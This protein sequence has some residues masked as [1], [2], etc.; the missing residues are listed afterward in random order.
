[1]P[2]SSL[3]PARVELEG[4]EH[5]HLSRVARVQAG[6]RIWLVDEEGGGYYAEVEG[7]G[8]QSTRLRII[9]RR[10]GQ[11]PALR[12][13]LMQALLKP[14]AM[15]WLIQKATE[16]GVSVIIPTSAERSLSHL[17]DQAG[18]KA[19]RWAAIVREAAKQCRSRFLP[20]IRPLCSLRDALLGERTSRLFYLSE[21]GGRPLRDV[22]GE[23]F[24]GSS[25]DSVLLGVGPE[26][27]W[28]VS[29]E[30]TLR[31]GGCQ[32]LSLGDRILRAETA[33]LC[34]ASAVLLL[35]NP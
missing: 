20:E 33:A 31:D 6:E 5:H 10:E 13:V 30:E 2:K 34:A 22:L 26:G 12:L 23:G 28:T 24:K 35:W 1:V 16:V 27:G 3:G 29:E 8:E 17:E 11:P 15:D 9:D 32:A 7:V 14:K 18:K 19:A 21:R 4:R 25:G